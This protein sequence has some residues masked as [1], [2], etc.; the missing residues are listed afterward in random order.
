MHLWSVPVLLI[1][2]FQDLWFSL[3]RAL[4]FQQQQEKNAIYRFLQAFYF[5]CVTFDDC[6]CLTVFLWF[7]HDRSLSWNRCFTV[8]EKS[9]KTFMKW[10]YD[11]QK[12]LFYFTCFCSGQTQW[13]EEL[14]TF[15]AL[16]FGN[17]EWTEN[18]CFR[19]EPKKVKLGKKGC[20]HIRPMMN[21]LEC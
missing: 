4:I 2:T 7:C 21:S 15:L 18:G 9:H 1:S 19:K 11:T 16:E 13:M 17:N 5:L 8:F 6:F 3:P 14:R 10:R 12:L 20:V